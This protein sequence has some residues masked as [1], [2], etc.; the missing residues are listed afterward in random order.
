[1]HK[2]RSDMAQI[3]DEISE[4]RKLVKSCMEWQAKLQHS[5]K[6]DILDA[7]FQSSE[8][9]YTCIFFFVFSYA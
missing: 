7:I 1:M 5:I 8:Y 4:L 2:L 3:H 6:Q 9:S